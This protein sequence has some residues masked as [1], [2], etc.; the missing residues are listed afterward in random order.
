MKP[1]QQQTTGF[2]DKLLQTNLTPIPTSKTTCTGNTAG[3][4][5][6]IS[7]LPDRLSRND[8]K[9]L[10]NIRCTI[11]QRSADIIYFATEA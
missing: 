2:M 6:L 5:Q 11:F 3:E 4:D 1:K 7:L 10:T 8:G 9:K